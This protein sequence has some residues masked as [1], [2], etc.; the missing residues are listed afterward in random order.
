M[1]A[2]MERKSVVA[3]GGISAPAVG[4]KMSRGWWRR[5]TCLLVNSKGR[6]GWEKADM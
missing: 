3:N 1:S 2:K 4:G 5:S 6:D